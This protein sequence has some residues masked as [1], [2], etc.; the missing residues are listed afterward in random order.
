[1]PGLFAGKKGEEFATLVAEHHL[2]NLYQMP[3]SSVQGKGS[4]PE[5]EP[6]NFI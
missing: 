4:P 6:L 5:R 1:M 3:L 2:G